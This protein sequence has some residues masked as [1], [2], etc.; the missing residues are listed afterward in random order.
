MTGEMF[1]L[2]ARTSRSCATRSPRTPTTSPHPNISRSPCVAASR[3]GPAVPRRDLLGPR[4]PVAGRR[5]GRRQSRLSLRPRHRRR[6]RGRAQDRPARRRTS[7][8]ASSARARSRA[9]IQPPSQLPAIDAETRDGSALVRRGLVRH[10]PRQRH[11]CEGSSHDPSRSSAVTARSS[12]SC[13]ASRP[14]RPRPVFDAL[15]DGR[16]H[17]DRGAA[18]FAGSLRLDRDDGPASP[19]RPR[20]GRR[21]HGADRGAGV[22]VKDVGGTLIVSPNANPAVIRETKAL[23]LDILSRASSR[24]PKPSPR[25][26]PAPTR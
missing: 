25:S 17:A 15:V 19:A 16:H 1:E 10:R 24:R 3:R 6:D 5:F 9:P 20:Q 18:Q 14:A 11:S 12:R 26:T 13:A 8:S 23:R 22:A 4:A 7:R 21:R 2:L